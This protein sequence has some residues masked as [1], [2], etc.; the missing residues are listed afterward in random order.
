VPYV[1]VHVALD[2]TDGRVVPGSN[3]APDGTDGRIVL[4][5]NLEGCDWQ[6]VRVGMPVTVV[7]D[8]D[9]LPRFRPV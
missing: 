4:V 7:F 6:S 9:G 5:S 2:G 1:I 8:A 3:V